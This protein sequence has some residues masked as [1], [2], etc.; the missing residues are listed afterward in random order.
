MPIRSSEIDRTR[1]PSRPL[2]C[3][4]DSVR[5]VSEFTRFHPPYTR[6]ARG[7]ADYFLTSRADRDTRK[8]TL[9]LLFDDTCW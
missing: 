5:R 3:N 7:P 1:Q 8:S 2:D 4:S 6:R 9:D